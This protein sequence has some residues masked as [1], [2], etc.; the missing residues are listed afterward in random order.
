MRK[1]KNAKK[2]QRILD[3]IFISQFYSK[4]TLN[5]E[6]RTRNVE[7]RSFKIHH[8]TFSIRCSIFKSRTKKQQN[9]PLNRL[10]L[11]HQGLRTEGTFLEQKNQELRTR[12]Q[13]QETKNKITINK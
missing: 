13:E 3:F 11:A 8:L 6:H 2:A 5:N 1:E 9:T 10:S 4:Y 12:N 7:F